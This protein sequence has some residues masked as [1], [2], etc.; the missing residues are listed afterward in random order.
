[1]LMKTD[2]VNQYVE[3]PPNFATAFHVEYEYAGGWGLSIGYRKSGPRLTVLTITIVTR[4]QRWQY[5]AK[6]MRTLSRSAQIGI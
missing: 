6:Q 5:G 4:R 1:M 2:L 3:V